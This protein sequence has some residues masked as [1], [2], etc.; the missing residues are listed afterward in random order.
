MSRAN[1]TFLN[2]FFL[3]VYKYVALIYFVD[4]DA[5]EKDG[6]YFLEI[7]EKENDRLLVL[8]DTAEKYLKIP[9]LPEEAKGVLRS[10]SGKARLL[11]SQK[12]QQF[13]GL[14]TKNITQVCSCG[15]V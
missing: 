6:H 10:A 4:S 5:E 15:F 11:V 8:A 3:Y 2:I 13:K 14:C 12:M 9:D 1:L 7:L